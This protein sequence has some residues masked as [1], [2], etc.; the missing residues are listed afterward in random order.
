MVDQN[1]EIVED[2]KVIY[3]I[4]NLYTRLHIKYGVSRD[5][6]KYDCY[7]L[8]QLL[9]GGIIVVKLQHMK[10]ILIKNESIAIKI[11]THEISLNSPSKLFCKQL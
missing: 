2:K 7:R 5:F 9:K 1:I 6:M 4:D 8:Q 11:F 3:I 10:A